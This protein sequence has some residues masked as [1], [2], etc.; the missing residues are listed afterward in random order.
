MT[1][2]RLIW[3]DIETTGLDPN[4]EML[5]EVGFKITDLELNVLSETSELFWSDEY[6]EYC[7]KKNIDPYVWEMHSKSKLWDYAK[8]A[9]SSPYIARVGII[10][11][12]EANNVTKN[13]PICGSSVQFDRGWLDVWIPEAIGQFSYRNIDVSTIKELCR[14]YNPEL[15]AKLAEDVTPKKEHR[16]LPDIDDTIE[17]FRGYR[18]SFLFWKD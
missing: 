14:R 7:V 9:G 4:K 8:R 2:E 17:E 13:E 16:A 6:A 3:C 5:L 11:W 18:D 15:Y 12:L 1:E 10:Q